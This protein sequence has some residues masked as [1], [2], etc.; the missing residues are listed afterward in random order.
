[1]A[2]AATPKEES[3]G[4]MAG[5]EVVPQLILLPQERGRVG[6]AAAQFHGNHAD[7]KKTP[8]KAGLFSH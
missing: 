5:G 7:Q 2:T 4:A 8:L 3:R 6:V 1:M